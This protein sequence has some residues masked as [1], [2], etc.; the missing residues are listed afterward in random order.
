MGGW[1]GGVKQKNEKSGGVNLGENNRIKYKEGEISN[2]G[3][4]RRGL[5]NAWI[6]GG[7]AVEHMH[8]F[9]IKFFF[10]NYKLLL[11]PSLN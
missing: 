11:A 8:R 1:G 3:A 7:M 6:C 9:K 2:C 4:Y 5:N 10:P